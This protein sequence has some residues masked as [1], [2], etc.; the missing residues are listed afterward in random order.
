MRN[1]LLLLVVLLGIWTVLPAQ[2]SSGKKDEVEEIEEIVEISPPK[3]WE[4][5]NYA[6]VERGINVQTPVS[7]RRGDWLF[8]ID[9][10]TRQA[11]RT[12]TFQDLLGFDAGGMKI[13][14]GL[15][16]AIL[17]NLETG[18]YRLNGTV[19][20]FDTYDFDLKCCLLNQ[21]QH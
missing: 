7:L 11:L 10:R 17:D 21:K 13:G 16:Y 3:L 15:R 4:S 12:D 8:V 1:T 19:E 18:F 20:I 2:S 6:V 14:I 9:H 5:D